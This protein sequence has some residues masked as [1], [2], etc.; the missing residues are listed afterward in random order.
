MTI[1]SFIQQVAGAE[2]ARVCATD[3]SGN[4][5]TADGRSVAPSAVVV[6]DLLK[7]GHGGIVRVDVIETA[8]V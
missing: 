6:G 3:G 1:Y 5:A 8:S 2:T 7:C 4:L